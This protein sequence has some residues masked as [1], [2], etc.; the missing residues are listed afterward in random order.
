[1]SELSFIEFKWDSQS[2]ATASRWVLMMHAI[3]KT[4]YKTSEEGQK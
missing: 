2:D 3:G 4:E 1:M